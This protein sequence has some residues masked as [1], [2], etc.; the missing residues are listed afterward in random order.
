MTSWRENGMKK[1]EHRQIATK[2]VQGNERQKL[3]SA[4]QPK[5]PINLRSSHTISRRAAKFILFDTTAENEMQ[6]LMYRL[7]HQIHNQNSCLGNPGN[8][9]VPTSYM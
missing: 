8:G 3:F 2:K 6:M 9:T 1:L 7:P 4:S 5:R